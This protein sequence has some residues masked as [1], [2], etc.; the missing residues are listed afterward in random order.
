MHGVATEV[1][2]DN[3]NR[4]VC[5]CDD[6]Q[7][8]ALFLDRPDALDQYGGTDIYQ[9][10]PSQLTITDGI[11]HLRCMRL[12]PK[13]LFRWYAGCC[14]TPIANTADTARAPFAG[15]IH[16]FMDH[17]ASGR[18]RDDVLGPPL[19]LLMA[20]FALGQPPAGAHPTV[21]PSI[22]VRTVKYLL[23]G[24]VTGKASPSPFFDART[25][26]PV[27]VPKVLTKEE[28]DA[29]RERY[30]TARAAASLG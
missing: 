7:A 12:S 10:T 25:K 20:K 9:T 26:S 23:K 17:D 2:P 3:G 24:L 8:F 30:L 5:M 27:V 11:E 14:N 15:V 6:C 19:G 4:I 1:R 22:M 29:I 16:T 13:G 21:P 18:S 28:R